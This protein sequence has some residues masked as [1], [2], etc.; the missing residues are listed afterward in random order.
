MKKLQ[1]IKTALIILS[2]T[3]GCRKEKRPEPVRVTC[4]ESCDYVTNFVN[5]RWI[6][7]GDYEDS[8]AYALSNIGLIPLPTSY[9]FSFDSCDLDNEWIINSNGTSYGLNHVKCQPSEQDTFEIPNW[10]I[11]DDRKTIIFEN[12]STLYI[13]SITPSYMKFYYYSTST[14]PGRPPVKYV[15]LQLYKSI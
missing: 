3:T 2:I 4:L 1:L 6:Q 8:S 10:K 9:S 5:H 7:V 14:F 12:A 15:R 11:S 13:E